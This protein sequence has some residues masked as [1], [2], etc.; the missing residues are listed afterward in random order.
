MCGV[1][2]CLDPDLEPVGIGGEIKHE[3]TEAEEA[4]VEEEDDDMPAYE[5]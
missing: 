4:V 3:V 2:W 1:C 5:V